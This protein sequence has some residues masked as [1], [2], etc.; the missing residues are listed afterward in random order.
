MPAGSEGAQPSDN[1]PTLQLRAREPNSR[2][3]NQPSDNFP[4]ASNGRRTAAA[5]KIILHASCMRGS[6]TS[7]PT[8]SRHFSCVRVNPICHPLH[9]GCQLYSRG[10]NQPSTAYC[11]PAVF[12]GAQYAIHQLPDS[13]RWAYGGCKKNNTGCQL[14]A[15]EPSHPTTSRH[16]SCARETNMPSTAY[17]MSAVFEGAKSAIRQLPGSHWI[18]LVSCTRGQ[19]T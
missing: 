10:P 15:R 14:Y 13:E 17:C 4:I 7:H 16:V 6:Q 18:L 8:T 2:G 12:E 19:M 3:P 1:F 5:R 9:T 11:M